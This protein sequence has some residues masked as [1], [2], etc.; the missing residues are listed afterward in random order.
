MP[1][2]RRL[3]RST[4]LAS[5]TVT[6]QLT[7]MKCAP[8]MAS[9]FKILSLSSYNLACKEGKSWRRNSVV[10]SVSLKFIQKKEFR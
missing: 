8:R 1:H 2:A 7:K 9:L 3:V 6:Y 10:V 5:V 4:P